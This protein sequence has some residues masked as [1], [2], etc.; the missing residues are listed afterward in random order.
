VAIDAYLQHLDGQIMVFFVLAAS[1]AEAAVGLAI[2][3]MLYQSYSEINTEKFSQ[4]S[5]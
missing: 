2:F 3:V 1:A 5:G 4:L